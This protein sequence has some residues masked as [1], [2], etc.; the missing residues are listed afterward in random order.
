MQVPERD[1]GLARI[2]VTAALVG[3]VADVAGV[4]G[5]EEAEGA[6]VDRQPEDRHVVG[7]HH[8]V[9]EAHCLPLRHQLGGALRHRFQQ[10][11]VGLRCVAAGRVVL[12]DHEVGQAA[13][14]VGVV[15]GVREVLEVAEADEARRHARAHRGGLDLLATHRQCRTGDA[16]RARRRNAEVMHRLRAEEL[17]DRRAQHCAAI[18]H[19]RVGRAAAA[20]ELDLLWAV[21]RVGLAKP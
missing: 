9:A 19:A 21:G 7:V 3:M 6:V 20:L 2:G 15:G 12:V 4:E 8:A 14:R 17:A 1:V 10:R 11:G 18:A 13:Q 16:Q 5:I